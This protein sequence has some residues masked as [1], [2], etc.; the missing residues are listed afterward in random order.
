MKGLVFNS[1]ADLVEDQYGIAVWNRVINQIDSAVDGAYVASDSYAAS[2]AL[3]IIEALVS[4]V[5]VPVEDLLD[6]FGRKLFTDL[7][8]LYPELVDCQ[9]ALL[10]FM[11]SVGTVIH[12]EMK[13][14]HRDAEVP[15]LTYE[16]YDRHSLTLFYQSP[17]KMCLLAEGL[18]RGAAKHYSSEIE[19]EHR[20]CMHNGAKK[21]EFH[22]RII[23]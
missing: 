9:T 21:C 19:L 8:N 1:L 18:M 17:R 22:L 6:E 16:L 5:R 3:A 13:I 2:E 20:E 4:E 10:P 15:I 12:E 23:N 7:Y 14:L 11:T